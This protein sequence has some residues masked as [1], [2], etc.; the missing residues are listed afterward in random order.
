M[1]AGTIYFR[2]AERPDIKLWILDDD[3]TLINFTGYT[4]TFKIGRPGGAA[5]VTKTSGITGAA[6]SGTESSGTPNVTIQFTAGE[7]DAMPAKKTTAQL[8]ATIAGVDRVWQWPFQ[9]LEVIS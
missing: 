7:T 5:L 3:G 2:T 4:F 8:R 9:V 1:T 6:G